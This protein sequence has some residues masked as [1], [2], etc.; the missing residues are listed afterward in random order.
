MDASLEG[1]EFVWRCCNLVSCKMMPEFLP[2][3][4]DAGSNAAVDRLRAAM[5][6]S[7]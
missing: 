5:R 4:N 7:P 6:L 3:V 2:R 1:S